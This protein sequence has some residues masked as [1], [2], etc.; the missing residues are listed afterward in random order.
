MIDAQPSVE[1]AARLTRSAVAN[2]LIATGWES[3]PTKIG[4][5]SMFSKWPSDASRPVELILPVVPGFTDESRRIADALRALEGLEGRALTLV[6]D[7]IHQLAGQPLRSVGRR[8][9]GS[10]VRSSSQGWN[11]IIETV[12]PSLISTMISLIFPGVL[13]LLVW[14]RP[15]TALPSLFT[16]ANESG[17]YAEVLIAII[18]ITLQALLGSVILINQLQKDLSRL[19]IIFGLLLPMLAIFSCQTV[20]I[21]YA[22]VFKDNIISPSNLMSINLVVLLNVISLLFL[23]A[24]TA[25][26]RARKIAE[27]A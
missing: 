7:E 14:D 27:P 8:G 2:Y 15:I 13:L 11:W 10:R 16:I 26:L 6:V 4:G 9:E 22:L 24:F 12:T 17:K 19:L 25:I 20:L 18:P 1:A 23:D 5:M 21:W 3:R